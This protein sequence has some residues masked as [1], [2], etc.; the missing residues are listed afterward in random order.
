MN[1]DQNNSLESMASEFVAEIKEDLIS[2]EPDLLTMEED[3]ADVD[4]DLINHAFRSI[5]SIKGGAGFINFTELSSLSHAME[6]VLMR[7]REKELIINPEIVDALL[8]GFDRMKQ[9]VDTIGTDEPCDFKEQ[10][11]ALKAILDPE[12]RS[13]D[14]K[15]TD[16]KKDKQ[17]VPSGDSI[18]VEGKDINESSKSTDRKPDKNP[19]DKGKT[20]ELETVRPINDNRFFT[21]KRFQVDKHRFLLAL[22]SQK[23]VYA[24]YIRIEKDSS[25]LAH[26]LKTIDDDIKSIG[27]ILYSDLDTMA[28]DAL[29]DGFFCVISTILDIPLLTQVLDIG[30][31]QLSLVSRKAGVSTADFSESPGM[32][33]VPPKKGAPG[34]TGQIPGLNGNPDTVTVGGKPTIRVNVDLVSRLMNR[35][36]ELVLS[37]NQLRPV[38]ESLGAE[39]GRLSNMMQ[40]LDM[41]TTDIQEA[42]MQMR[43]QPVVDLMGKYKRVVRDIARRMSKQVVFTLGGAHVEVDRNILEKLA[44]PLTHLI[45]NCIDHGIEP[46]ERRRELGKPE[47]GTIHVNASHQ[48]GYIRITIRD[49]GAGIDPQLVLSKAFEKGLV[50]EEELDSLTDKQKIDL[51]FL[52]GFSTS[53]KI[54]DISGRG[55]GM[56]VVKTNL[57][58]LRGQIDIESEKGQGTTVCLLIPLTLAIVPSLVVEASGNRFVIP[59]VNI[60]EVIYLEPGQIQEQVQNIAGSELLRLRDNLIPV[61][62]LRNVLSMASYVRQ[63]DG[64]ESTREKRKAIADRRHASA[65]V[66][67]PDNRSGRTDR[68]KNS[69]D[70]TYVI[71]LKLG[72]HLFG[73]CV[74]EVYDIEEVV[75]EPLSEYI[76]HLKCFAG[77]TILGDGKVTMILDIPGIASFS[78]LKFDT[79][80]DARSVLGPSDD[81]QGDNQGQLKNLIVFGNEKKEFFA[82]ALEH[83]S[84][85]EPIAV[86]D[87]HY[88]G[89]QRFFEYK[90]QDVH[91]FAMDAFL[92]VHPWE[93]SDSIFVIFP[94]HTKT[95]VGIMTP[96]IVDT[97]E[98]RS[99]LARDP[100]GP[101]VVAGKLFIDDRMIQVL[102]H[103]VLYERIEQ[104]VRK[105]AMD[106]E[107]RP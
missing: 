39:D 55:V 61:L 88:T 95:R 85:L 84:R 4:D 1:N 18:P 74:D 97:I 56:D 101:D 81:S 12:K 38:L 15:T 49:D 16:S 58:R 63:P 22:E 68:R 75:V 34:S 52:P 36:G 89:E 82:L 70:A 33:S 5:H 78:N 24:V 91:L 107:S 57:K 14:L 20:D 86:S 72:P 48:G 25:H 71:I 3:G 104:R 17:P 26:K 7:V 54:T 23:F 66:K 99:K 28:A 60:K 80:F 79:A 73:L 100:S 27:D 13:G 83:I 40:N 59:Q 8:A 96:V 6:N 37:R 103:D 92:S 77:T 10:E 102:D 105:D 90:N 65:P 46:P 98:T 11:E 35:A 67:D 69:W 45:R 64:T 62:R 30:K 76:K 94:K 53:E 2:L 106:V 87:I 9:M 43:M 29:P 44:N 47:T 50:P 19:G 41:V 93:P 31:D 42:I 32:E 51:I 21:Q